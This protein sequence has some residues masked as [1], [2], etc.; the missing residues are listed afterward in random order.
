MTGAV[1]SSTKLSTFTLFFL[2]SMASFSSSSLRFC[3]SLRRFC[4]SSAAKRFDFSSILDLFFDS[5]SN[6]ANL[7]SNSMRFCLSCSANFLDSLSS[8][9]TILVLGIISSLHSKLISFA[10]SK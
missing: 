8:L 7:F 6:A 1:L 4:F 9:I 10:N 5:F 2:D 3:S